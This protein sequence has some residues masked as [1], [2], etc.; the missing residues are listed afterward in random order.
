MASTPA[1]KLTKGNARRYLTESKLLSKGA[2]SIYQL[3]LQ[4]VQHEDKGDPKDDFR[5]KL[6]H[7]ETNRSQADSQTSSV[8]AYELCHR[9]G[10]RIPYSLIIIDTPGFGDTRGIEYDELITE[11]IKEFFTSL[12]VNEINV[13]CFVTQAPLARLTPTQKYIFD[14]ILS[15]FGKDIA[16]NILVLVTFA[17]AHVPPVLEAINQSEIPCPKD[18]KGQPIHFKFNNS[19]VFSQTGTSGDCDS[20]EENFDEIYWKMGST[21]MKKFFASLKSIPPKSLSLTKEVL[22]AETTECYCAG[23]ATA[24]QSGSYQTGGD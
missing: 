15:I 9:E 22:R 5:Y 18:N 16:E 23:I 19:A 10:F 17:D 4:S 11:Q 14:S 2:P 3:Q 20:D 24:D 1:E 12:H 8:T 21:N 13:V 7:E 6:I